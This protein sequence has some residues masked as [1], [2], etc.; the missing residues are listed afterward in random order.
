M[1]ITKFSDY[2]LRTLVYLGDHSDEL[3]TIKEISDYYGIVHSH[4]TKVVHLLSTSGFI[5]SVRGRNGGLRL[6]KDPQLIPLG[7]VIRAT[8]G[9]LYVLDCFDPK[10]QTCRLLPGCKLKTI[11]GAAMNSFFAHLDNTT[12]AD[13][14]IKK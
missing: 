6:A 11:I 2:A 1:Q 10:K 13:V 3:V 5:H 4:L 8:E 14:L 7:S 12:L 9:K